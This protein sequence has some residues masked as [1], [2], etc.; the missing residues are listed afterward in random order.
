MKTIILFLLSIIVVTSL[1]AQNSDDY[2]EEA[3]SLFKIKSFNPNSNKKKCEIFAYVRVS[4]KFKEVS[5][6]IE[7]I[8]NQQDPAIFRDILDFK[9]LSSMVVAKSHRQKEDVYEFNFGI[10]NISEYASMRMLV[11]YNDGGTTIIPLEM[12]NYKNPIT[13]MN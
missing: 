2:I 3:F 8:P 13:I 9:D 1:T 7:L 5:F 12:T 4:D 11:V 6:Y 10:F